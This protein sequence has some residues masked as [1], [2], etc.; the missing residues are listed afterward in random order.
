[1]ET[2]FF[3]QSSKETFNEKLRTSFSESSRISIAIAYISREGL[4]AIKSYIHASHSIRIV[5]GIHG[6]ISDLKALTDFSQ[7]F[8]Q[9]EGH[10]FLG[11][12]L[13]HPKLYVFQND[14]NTT[15]WIGSANLTRSGLFNNEETLIG[16][17]G[18]S[19]DITLSTIRSYFDDLWEKRSVPV[20]YYLSKHPDYLVKNANTELTKTQSEIIES[21]EPLLSLDDQVLTFEKNVRKEIYKNGKVTIPKSFDS[22]L[23]ALRYCDMGDSRIINLIMPNGYKIKARFYHSSNNTTSYYQFYICEQSDKTK[24]RE[25]LERGATL[26]FKFNLINHNVKVR[27]IRE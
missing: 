16:L 25:H 4:K 9:A 17:M 22:T 19:S 3:C 27:R 12:K 8:N 21:Y 14:D 6:C 15:V 2:E 1:M 18:N 5:C 10:V 26:G 7:E 24:F 23:D 20:D 13:F 11:T